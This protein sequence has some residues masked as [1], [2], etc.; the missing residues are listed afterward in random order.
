MMGGKSKRHL[1]P[2]VISGQPRYALCEKGE[3]EVMEIADWS[4]ARLGVIPDM[5]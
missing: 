3:I 1:V 2:G 5:S 4:L